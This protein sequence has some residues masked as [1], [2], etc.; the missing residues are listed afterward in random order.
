MLLVSAPPCHPVKLSLLCLVPLTPLTVFQLSCKLWEIGGT[1]RSCGFI[2]VTT[3]GGGWC[4]HR[5]DEA[6]EAVRGTGAQPR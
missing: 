5:G 6:A 1:L 4:P 2:L 3:L